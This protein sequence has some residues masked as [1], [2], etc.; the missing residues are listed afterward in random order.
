MTYKKVVPLETGEKIVMKKSEFAQ[1]IKV[2]GIR[3]RTQPSGHLPEAYVYG[4]IECGPNEDGS[5]WAER[6]LEVPDITRVEVTLTTR[7]AWVR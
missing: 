7:K 4:P 2:V 3:E 1:T 5:G 6:L